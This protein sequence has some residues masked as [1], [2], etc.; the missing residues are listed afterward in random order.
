MGYD[1]SALGFNPATMALGKKASY[2]VTMNTNAFKSDANYYGANVGFTTTSTTGSQTGL[3]FPV[4]LDTTH[5]LVLGLGYTQSKDYNLGYQYEGINGGSLSFVEALADKADPLSRML[6]LSYPTYDSSGNFL[7]DHTV[8]GPE[9]YERGYLLDE[10]G[11]FHFS[12]GASVE[13]V[14]NV[15]FGVSGNYNIS[16]YN[17]DLE[18][19]AV[20]TN[21][22]YPVGVLTIPDN[23]STDG[24]ISTNYRVVRS[25]QYKGWDVRFGVLYKLENFIS[26]SASFKAPTSH[27]VNEDVFISGKSQFSGNHSIVV[28]ET[29][30]TSSYYF[31]PPAEMTLGA[32]VNLWILTGTLQASYVDYADMKIT[33]GVGELPARTQINK[34]IKDELSAVVNLNMG[35]EFRLPFTGLSARAGGI[36]QPSPYKGDKSRYDQK[37]LTAGIG[38]NSNNIMQFDM[39]Y[40]YGWRGE[41]KTQQEVNDSGSEQQIAYHTVLFTMRFAPCSRCTSRVSS[42]GKPVGVK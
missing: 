31:S 8:L 15:F 32:M 36:Y 4:R 29:K 35:A 23:P 11:M 6:G 38:I 18:L 28:P 13:A 1:F 37:F 41:H 7:G 34:R 33:G 17:S 5:N 20:D 30:S 21:D 27:R 40:A 26:L 19:T 24:F 42:I 9:M 3:T 22:V 12:A 10:G 2:S 25:K 39:A 16:P 14:R